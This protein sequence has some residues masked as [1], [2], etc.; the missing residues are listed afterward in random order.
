MIVAPKEGIEYDEDDEYTVS[1]DG[2]YALISRLATKSKE[3]T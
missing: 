2:N 1:S 3:Q